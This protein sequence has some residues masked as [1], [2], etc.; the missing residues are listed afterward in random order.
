MKQTLIFIFAILIFNS[1]KKE[2]EET[3]VI[4]DTNVSALFS[5]DLVLETDSTKF[6][7][8][9]NLSKGATKFKWYFGSSDSS[10][11][12]E[13]TFKVTKDGRYDVVLIASNNNKSSVKRNIVNVT[14]RDTI[15][16]PYAACKAYYNIDSP[17]YVKFKNTS[18]IYRTLTWLVDGVVRSNEVNPTIH[19]TVLG[20]RNIRLIAE[21]TKG[22]KNIKDFSIYLY[23][24]EEFSNPVNLLSN[25]NTGTIIIQQDGT[26]ALKKEFTH[27]SY[28]DAFSEYPEIFDKKATHIFNSLSPQNYYMYLKSDELTSYKKYQTYDFSSASVLYSNILGNYNFK[29]RMKL[30]ST[31]NS[32]NIDTTYYRDTMLN[33]SFIN[34]SKLEI[35]DNSLGHTF[36]GYLSSKSNTNSYVFWEEID[37]NPNTNAVNYNLITIPKNFKTLE[38]LN[39]NFEGNI[40]GSYTTKITYKGSR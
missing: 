12:Y 18:N 25:I 19:F 11:E 27:I 24:L 6:F 31:S 23:S 17:N 35:I 4:N 3:Q 39:N 16:Y 28:T 10:S 14:F 9:N 22:D 20:R 33:L 7:K 8:F 32:S 15:N 30:K 38:V 1:C 29:K 13:P 2:E 37:F 21:N 34:N 40:I 36:T 5:Y 26:N